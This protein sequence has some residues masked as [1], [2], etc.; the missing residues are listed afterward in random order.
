VWA[1]NG[2]GSSFWA[3]LGSAVA[4]TNSRSPQFDKMQIQT[5]SQL[6]RP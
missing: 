6:C 1:F 4:T 3:T 5:L 2:G